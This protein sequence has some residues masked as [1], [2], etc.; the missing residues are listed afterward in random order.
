MIVPPELPFDDLRYCT[1][2]LYQRASKEFFHVEYFP[3]GQTA[4]NA[5]RSLE[6]FRQLLSTDTLDQLIDI[7]SRTLA[8]WTPKAVLTTLE[9]SERR[10]ILRDIRFDGKLSGSPFFIIYLYELEGRTLLTSQFIFRPRTPFD[11]PEAFSKE[12]AAKETRWLKDLEQASRAVHKSISQE[13]N[14]G[15][16]ANRR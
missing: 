12:F 5:A 4:S 3:S 9:Q 1:A 11:S 6:F 14:K 7:H 8:E 13:A 2:G 15:A 16:A 10:L